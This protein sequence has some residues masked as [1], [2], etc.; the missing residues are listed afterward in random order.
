M[1]FPPQINFLTLGCRDVER[2]TQLIRAFGWPEA[3]SSDEHHRV[4]QLANGVVLALYTS[5]GYEREYG[6]RTDGFA[7]VTIGVN[8][9]SRDEVLAA[10]ASLSTIDGV[11]GLDEPIDS[12]HGF[13]GFA[14][15]DPEGNVWEV[16]WKVGSDVD[17]RGALTWG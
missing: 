11:D 17:E 1:T 13:S 14:F 9:A 16:G 3:P 5:A 4:F 15:R 7:G 6:A 2:M 12:P 10:H 8:L